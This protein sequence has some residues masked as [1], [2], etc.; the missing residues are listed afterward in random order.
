[1]IRVVYHGNPFFLLGRIWPAMKSFLATI[2]IILL[3]SVFLG[4]STTEETASP[5]P[6]EKT[7]RVF[8]SSMSLSY[9]LNTVFSK[10]NSYNGSVCLG[11]SG[12]VAGRYEAI[13]AATRNA[14]QFLAFSQG[15]AMQTNS[16]AVIRTSADLEDFDADTFG[17]TADRIYEEAASRMEIEKVEWYAD[18]IGAVVYARLPEM[19][20]VNWSGENWMEKTPVIEGYNVAVASSEL[21]YSSAVTAI[22]AATFR[23]A[24]ALL[25]VDRRTITVTNSKVETGL[26]EDSSFYSKDMYTISG[27]RLEGFRV[28]SYY[29]DESTQKVFALGI[30]KRL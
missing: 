18:R 6:E 22:E 2:M 25:D 13:K 11:V 21:V 15:L 7:S 30:S 5:S 1:M 20:M 3:V 10:Y 9:E 19:E 8:N 27:N 14:L 26:E 24:Q 17:G 23:V 4:C 29:Y 16:G 28:L 12:P